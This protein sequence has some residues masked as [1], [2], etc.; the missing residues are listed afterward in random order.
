MNTEFRNHFSSSTAL[1]VSLF[2]CPRVTLPASDLP[3]PLGQKAGELLAL[4]LLRGRHCHHR[5][6]LAHLLWPDSPSNAAAHSLRTTLW[7]LRQVLEP[8]GITRGTYLANGGSGE[9]GFNWDSDV[10]VDVLEFRSTLGCCEQASTLLASDADLQAL[11]R[12]L[13]LYEGELL[14]GHCDDWIVYE[15]ER[16]RE[17][18]IRGLC[19]MLGE[20]S[21]RGE[22]Q[23]AIDCG[24][25]VLAEN[26]LHESVHRELMS[27]Y[28]KVGQRAEA[29]RLYERLQQTLET[30]L[31]VAPTRET[32]NVYVRILQLEQCTRAGAAGRV[33]QDVA[34]M[35]HSL[36]TS[37]DALAREHERMADAVKR[38]RELLS[39][40][41][42]PAAGTGTESNNQAFL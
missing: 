23:Q 38:V 33:E 19:Y 26:P 37:L 13:R 15:R 27:L 25:R 22:F 1:Q 18:F 10:R 16:L 2:G 11:E 12:A 42:S 30:E 9:V 20:Q 40:A 8:T 39:A 36:Q 28:A 7:R 17:L 34:A 21:R 29:I 6:K 24:R 4:L 32:T 31:E 5:E 3:K 35:L 41:D 14:E